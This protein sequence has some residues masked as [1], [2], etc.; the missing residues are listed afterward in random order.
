MTYAQRQNRKRQS[1]RMEI[2]V[3]NLENNGRLKTVQS[4]S[5]AGFHPDSTTQVDPEVRRQAC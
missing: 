1:H 4:P 3:L 5:R 2:A